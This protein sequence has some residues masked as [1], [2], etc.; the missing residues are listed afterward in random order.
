MNKRQAKKK[1]KKEQQKQRMAD[2]YAA[3]AELPAI[4]Q[5]VGE[6]LRE[7]LD[8]MS[9]AL[10]QIDLAEVLIRLKKETMK[11]HV[12]EII[13]P[14]NCVVCGEPITDDGLLL[15]QACREKNKEEQDAAQN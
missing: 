7:A 8:R 15:C 3:I 10:S 4:A 1:R 13:T 5:K 2:L 6:G 12:T 9:E 11:Q 14:G